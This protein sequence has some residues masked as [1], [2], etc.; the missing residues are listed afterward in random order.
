MKRSEKGLWCLERLQSL[1][2]FLCFLRAEIVLVA[3]IIHARI[4]CPVLSLQ[5]HGNAT[6]IQDCW[7]LQTIAPSP[8]P[9]TREPLERSLWTHALEAEMATVLLRVALV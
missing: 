4:I 3:K 6:G 5:R 8:E 7:T 1:S 2:E 9:P